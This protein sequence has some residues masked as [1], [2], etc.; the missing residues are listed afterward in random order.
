MTA[1]HSSKK[2]NTLCRWFIGHF[3]TQ[4]VLKSACPNL[5]GSLK[6]DSNKGRDKRYTRA[7]FKPDS[8]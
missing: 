8:F 7:Y 2:T 1:K 3:L 4:S 6:F 5:D